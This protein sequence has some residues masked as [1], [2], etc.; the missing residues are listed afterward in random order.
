[1]WGKDYCDVFPLYW[2]WGDNWLF[3]P[4]A[5]NLNGDKAVLPV[6]WGKDH[7]RVLP[8]YWKSGEDQALYPF[9]WHVN[10]NNG[11][12][13]VWWGKNYFH[14]FPLYWQWNDKTLILPFIYDRS[15]ETE[16]EFRFLWSVIYYHRRGE[17]SEFAFQPLFGVH[18]AP[19]AKRVSFL[20]GIVEFES[21]TA[22]TSL[23]KL[24]WMRRNSSGT[25]KAE[26]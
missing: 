18:R 15:N 26:P 6:M 24:F 13:P 3:L 12:G 17:S 16:R 4:L 14:V 9:A 10:G 21:T 11:I 19:D 20:G 5:W 22:G 8:L 7:V 23:R 25:T 2:Q 1:V